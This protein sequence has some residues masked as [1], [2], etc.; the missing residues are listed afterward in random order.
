MLPQRS[1]ASISASSGWCAGVLIVALAHARP[2]GSRV[3]RRGRARR[4]CLSRLRG[5][6]AALRPCLAARLMAS[7]SRRPIPCRCLSLCTP[8]VRISA[9]SAASLAQ[10]EPDCLRHFTDSRHERGGAWMRQKAPKTFC[11]PGLGKEHGM[12][13]RKLWGMLGR[14]PEDAHVAIGRGA[15]HG[16]AR[17]R[18]RA[19]WA[20]TS[21]GRR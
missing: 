14:R 9:S 17:G 15:S 8:R 6:G 2:V 16:M 4:C 21:G 12:K 5:K 19:A 7:T 13:L 18:D 10:N 20:L 3:S 11:V 1:S